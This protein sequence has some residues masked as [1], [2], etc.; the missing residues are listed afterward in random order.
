MYFPPAWNC[1]TSSQI[2]DPEDRQV[3]NARLCV[4]RTKC[5]LWPQDHVWILLCNY[6]T[7]YCNCKTY[8]YFLPLTCNP[9]S[10]AAPRPTV[11][12]SLIW[13]QCVKLL[14]EIVCVCVSRSVKCASII[15][16]KSKLLPYWMKHF[17]N[18]MFIEDL[19][20][21]MTILDSSNRKKTTKALASWK[22]WGSWEGGRETRERA[23]CVWMWTHP[24]QC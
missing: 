11:K 23:Q 24:A 7:A 13:L 8:I 9:G 15:L 1:L 10:R 19:L 12:S 20:S 21:T 18:L 17:T 2:W 14:S 6:H 4:A 5:I 22:R 16:W 3:T